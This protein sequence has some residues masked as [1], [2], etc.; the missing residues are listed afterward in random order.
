MQR[1]RIG[2]RDYGVDTVCTLEMRVHHGDIIFH[3]NAEGEKIPARIL[4]QLQ[5]FCL[6][7]ELQLCCKFYFNF[8]TLVNS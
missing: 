8:A 6:V 1:Q 3:A 7:S 5:V 4:S 2:K